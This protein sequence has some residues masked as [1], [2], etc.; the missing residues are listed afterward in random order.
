LKALAPHQNSPKNTK[1]KEAR[2]YETHTAPNHKSQD[3]RTREGAEER[4]H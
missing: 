2:S 4:A 3:L 1:V